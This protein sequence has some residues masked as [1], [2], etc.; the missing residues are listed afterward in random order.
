MVFRGGSLALQSPHRGTCPSELAAGLVSSH[1]Y[2]KSI[3]G[4]KSTPLQVVLWIKASDVRR[5]S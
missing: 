4:E 1:V 5:S 2:R 3:D